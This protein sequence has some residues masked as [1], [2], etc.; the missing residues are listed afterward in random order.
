MGS[1]IFWVLLMIV[2]AFILY[3]MVVH[4]QSTPH[5]QSK[6]SRFWSALVAAGI[7]AGALVMGLFQSP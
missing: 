7:A 5:D 3:A 6:A 1:A 2:V 4:Y